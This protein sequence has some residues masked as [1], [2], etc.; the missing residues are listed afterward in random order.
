LKIQPIKKWHVR[1]AFFVRWIFFLYVFITYEKQKS[2]GSFSFALDLKKCGWILIFRLD[3]INSP[4]S[5][6][7]PLR[8]YTCQASYCTPL[9]YVVM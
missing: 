5:A 7:C 9:V 4:P 3:L 6:P 8:E 1:V 2:S